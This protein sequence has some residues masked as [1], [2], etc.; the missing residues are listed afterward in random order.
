MPNV[1][2]FSKAQLLA[3]P[4]PISTLPY[5]RTP[6]AELTPQQ[7][8]EREHR[9]T[10]KR[11]KAAAQQQAA[12]DRRRAEEQAQVKAEQQKAVQQRQQQEQ[13]V[14]AAKQRQQAVANRKG[15]AAQLVDPRIEEARRSAA[16]DEM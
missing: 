2:A 11:Q 8:Q 1:P 4:T 13:R 14:Q 16:Y 9:G 10:A 6:V 5:S 15:K 3:C 7:V 12:V